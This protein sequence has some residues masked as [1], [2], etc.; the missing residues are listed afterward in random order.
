MLPTWLIVKI[1]EDE[2]RRREEEQRPQPQLD[3]QVPLPPPAPVKKDDEKRG[4]VYI[5]F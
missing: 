1:L 2:R 5:Q 3:I 4:V